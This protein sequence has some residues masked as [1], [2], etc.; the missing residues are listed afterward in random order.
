MFAQIASI[1]VKT[2]SNT[3]LIAS[4][5][6]KL[7]KGSLPV[8]VRRSKTSLL[9]LPIITFR[10]RL[11]QKKCMLFYLAF[12]IKLHAGDGY[13]CT[14][15]VVGFFKINL[16]QFAF[17]S[18]RWLMSCFEISAKNGMCFSRNYLTV[19]PRAW[20]G[21]K[22]LRGHEGKRNNCFSKMQIGPNRWSK[23]SRQNNLS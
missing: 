1:R 15:K 14:G 19:I 17:I 6:F 5:Q 7:E 21:S 3:N 2:L 13:N 8:D 20:M 10:P 16:K 12:D 23:I 22:S 9:K 4:R 11:F 18:K